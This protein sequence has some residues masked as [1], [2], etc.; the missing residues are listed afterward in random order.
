MSPLLSTVLNSALCASSLIQAVV[1]FLDH[2][3]LKVTN[4][5]EWHS[6]AWFRVGI[7]LNVKNTLTHHSGN[8]FEATI[9]YCFY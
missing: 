1:L 6:V 2:P 4:A 9:W 7:S 8:I 5:D 3:V